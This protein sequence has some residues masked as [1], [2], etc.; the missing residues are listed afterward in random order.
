MWAKRL[1][2]YDRRGAG[3]EKLH[4]FLN[5]GAADSRAILRQWQDGHR[6]ANRTVEA[7]LQLVADPLAAVVNIT[8]ASIIPVGG[9]LATAAGL[10]SALDIAVRARIL[11]KTDSPVVVPG[12][13]GSEG[14]L[15]GAAIM[16]HRQ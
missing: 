2:R 1:C 14:G 15:I 4:H 7:Y 5:G 8:G 13:F 11:R 6:E 16:G 9:G 10:I 3:I 12:K